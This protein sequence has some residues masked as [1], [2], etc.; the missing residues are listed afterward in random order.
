MKR[1]IALI[2]ISGITL[3]FN[4]PE[5]HELYMPF[6]IRRSPATAISSCNGQIVCTVFED[7][8]QNHRRDE[9]EVGMPDV[10]LA[11]KPMHSR[12]ELV[13]HT[14]YKGERAVIVSPGKYI[15]RAGKPSTRGWTTPQMWGID[16][17]CATIQIDFG[18]VTPTEAN[19]S[20][21]PDSQN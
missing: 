1:I 3:G 17:M 16:I 11:L 5:Q 13:L 6:L 15:I 21:L 8:N 9:N 10:Q 20:E 4:Q 19:A 2:A 12:N 7:L 14:N 18:I